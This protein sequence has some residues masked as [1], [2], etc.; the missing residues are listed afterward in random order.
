MY[1]LGKRAFGLALCG[2]AALLVAGVV[3]AHAAPGSA[4]IEAGPPADPACQPLFFGTTG[5]LGV[6]DEP[7]P[8]SAVTGQ[9][10]WGAP[11][12]AALKLPS[13]VLLKD[14][15]HAVSETYSFALREG[16]LFARRSTHGIPDQGSTWREVNLPECLDGK[17]TGISADRNLLLAV[18]PGRQVYS[19][20]MPDGDLNPGRWTWRWGPYFW[21][22]SGARLPADLNGFATSDLSTPDTFTDG[23]GRRHEPI[24]VATLFL[25][26]DQ[27]RRITYL[28]PWL[29]TD[30][31]REVCLPD[32]GTSQLAGMDA[33]GSTL[34]VAARSGA[35][36]TR[37]YDF[38]LTGANAVFG[39]YTWETGLPAD[40]A[41]WQLPIPDW[42][43]QPTPP[44]EFTDRVTIVSTGPDAGDRE[45]RVEGRAGGVT[46]VWVKQIDAAQW[47]FVETGAALTGRSLPVATTP[48]DRKP[49]RYLGAMGGARAEIAAF[50]WACTPTRVQVRI[51][52]GAELTLLLHAY[53]GMRQAPRARGLND[54]P[55]EYNAALEVP[56]S[57]WDELDHADPRV[58]AWVRANLTGRFTVSPV[59]ATATRLR[60]LGPCWELTLDGKP[61]RAD[62]LSQVDVGQLAGRLSQ[63]VNDGRDPGEC[64]A[65]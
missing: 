56:E 54:E 40:S 50:D 61:P 42:K 15:R 35:I 36:F 18:G 19:H 2:L 13:R 48:I 58:R 22:G 57:T 3:P 25:L 62:V 11:A 24:G 46:G 26:R 64:F 20:S 17:L 6:G 63:I 28:D 8:L 12:P 5:V 23:A 37:M 16:R 53:D 30:G 43:R 59:S 65:G 49:R 45:L 29:P 39:K 60:F 31:S 55:R 41:A 4:H 38:D 33:T 1:R 7:P 47:R 9:G 34:I 51:G 10:T 52:K 44:G 21:M 32:A 14:A 27:G